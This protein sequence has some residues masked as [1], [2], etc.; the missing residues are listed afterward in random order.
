[1]ARSPVIQEEWPGVRGGDKGMGGWGLPQK[2]STKCFVGTPGLLSQTTGTNVEQTRHL[3]KDL[4]RDMGEV[5]LRT[6]NA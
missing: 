5:L 6:S 2:A 4:S 3:E 1:M